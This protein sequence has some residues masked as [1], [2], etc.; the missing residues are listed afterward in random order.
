MP[1]PPNRFDQVLTEYLVLSAQDGNADALELLARR[2]HGRL[3]SHARRL[4]DQP[5]GGEDVMQEA[6][7]SILRQLGRLRDPARFGPWA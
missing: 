4:T 7:G 5:D 1:T 2:W 3:L 6:W